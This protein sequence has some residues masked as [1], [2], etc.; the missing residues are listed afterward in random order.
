LNFNESVKRDVEV[1]ATWNIHGLQK[2]VV[3]LAQIEPLPD[4]KYRMTGKTVVLL[5]DFKI[6]VKSFGNVEVDNKCHLNVDVTFSKI[7]SELQ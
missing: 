5:S 4:N 2:D 6:Q 7:A 1:D 3:L